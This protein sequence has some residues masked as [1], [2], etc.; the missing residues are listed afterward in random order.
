MLLARIGV[1]Y[2]LRTRPVASDPLSGYCQQK[3]RVI[4]LPVDIP[5]D[6]KMEA[7]A[8]APSSNLRSHCLNRRSHQR[9]DRRSNHRSHRRRLSPLC[10]NH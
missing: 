1:A 8:M 2:V 6:V 3:R 4:M 10:Q 9:R 5:G 7:L